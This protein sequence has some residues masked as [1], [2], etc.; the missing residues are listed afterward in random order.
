M[1]CLYAMNLYMYLHMHMMCMYM[2]VYVHAYMYMY[3]L[4]CI[5]I[6]KYV[7]V[8]V[9]MRVYVYVY[10][11]QSRHILQLDIKSQRHIR[12]EEKNLPRPCINMHRSGSQSLLHIRLTR[13]K[14]SLCT[15]S[16]S[17][18][19]ER[20]VAAGIPWAARNL[21]CRMLALIA[22]S[23]RELCYS[24]RRPRHSPLCWSC[25]ACFI[26]AF[27]MESWIMYC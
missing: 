11:L 10:V 2:Y 6:S 18:Q 20:Q 5:R 24:L 15:S 22:D 9:Y 27:G 13:T 12:T 21:V 7:C 23:S 16:K 4:Y 19:N 14:R 25:F 17:V 3:M 26:F 8:F 1:Q